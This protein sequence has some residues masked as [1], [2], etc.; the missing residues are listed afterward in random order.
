MNKIELSAFAVKIKNV[1]KQGSKGLL[2][3]L[4]MKVRSGALIPDIFENLSVRSVVNYKWDVWASRALRIQL[5]MF[6]GLLISFFTFAYL[7]IVKI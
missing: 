3:P 1:A 4:I 5:Y 2:H 6:I 7:Y